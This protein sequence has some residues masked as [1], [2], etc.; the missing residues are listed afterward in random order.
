LASSF[1]SPVV[2]IAATTSGA[3]YLFFGWC[4]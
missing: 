1:L 4:S 3:A 2:D